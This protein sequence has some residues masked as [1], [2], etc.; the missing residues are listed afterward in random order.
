VV[1]ALGTGLANTVRARS[2]MARM[3]DAEG[4][5]ELL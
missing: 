1:D 4:E 2:V 5:G 3:T